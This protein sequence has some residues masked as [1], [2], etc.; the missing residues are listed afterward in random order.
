VDSTPCRTYF[1][2][3]SEENKQL[4]TSYGA[5]NTASVSQ[6]LFGFFKYYAHE[7]DFRRS[8]VSIVAGGALSKLSKAESDG[9]AQ[10]ERLS[11]EDPFETSYDVAH[12]IKSP[13]MMYLH[14]EFLRAHT[15]F[16]RSSSSSGGGS[17]GGGGGGGSGADS[18]PHT[19][20]PAS[21]IDILCEQ[22]T[23][24][25]LPKFSSQYKEKVKKDQQQ[26]QQQQQQAQQQLDE[27]T[28]ATK[29]Q[30]AAGIDKEEEEEEN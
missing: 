8:I 16:A 10:H 11:I 20:L 12:V 7:F 1:F 5:A 18:L 13:Q 14:K 27:S 9:W 19:L 6:L 22:P 25:Q 30:A 29:E 26:Q 23:H 21:L 28:D 3:P 15:L 4:F 2:T 24:E 17:S